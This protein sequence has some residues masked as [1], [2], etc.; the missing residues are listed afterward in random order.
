MNADKEG[1]NRMIILNENDFE[2]VRI[3]L[4]DKEKI[5]PTFV[6]SVLDQH[7]RGTVYADSVTP[8]TALIG[9]ES[10][11]YFVVG[12]ENNHDFNDYLFDLYNQRKKKKLRFTL[13]SSNENWD[14]VIKNQF[15]DMLRQMSRYSFDYD[16]KKQIDDKVLPKEYSIRRINEELLVNSAEFNEDYYKEY[17]GTVSNFC[18]YGFGYC[19][20]HNGK[21]VSEC[22]S[23]FSSRHYSEMDIATH[24]EYRGQGLA[25]II[26]NAFIHH[27]LESNRIPRWDCDTGNK[28]SIKLAGNLG[29]VNPVQYSIFV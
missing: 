23:I 19:I 6:L 12:N 1:V 14:C 25:S 18:N 21:V 17:W 26:A 28:S 20:L 29:F 22:T 7:I 3:G 4:E 9:T 10:G 8:Q 5:L 16:R 11:V 27:C 15:K 2:R 24:K 13:F